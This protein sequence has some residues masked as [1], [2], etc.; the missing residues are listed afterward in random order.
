MVC[1]QVVLIAHHQPIDVLGAAPVS[2]SRPIAPEQLPKRES[3]VQ[4]GGLQMQP[5][6]HEGEAAFAPASQPGLNERGRLDMEA[7]Q[8]EVAVAPI[9]AQQLLP[10]E[11]QREDGTKEVNEVVLRPHDDG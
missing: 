6:G 5:R 2:L 7:P 4:D 11:A 1:G 10:L 8:C 3:I 9:R